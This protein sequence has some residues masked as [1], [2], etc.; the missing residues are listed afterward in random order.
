MLIN[1][2]QK[3]KW[4][5][6]APAE[7]LNN[8]I[9]TM[10]S[11]DW[12][13]EF[14]LTFNACF[15]YSF[16]NLKASLPPLCALFGSLMVSVPIQYYGRRKSLIGLCVPLMFGFMLMGFTYFARHK[17][18]LYI[19]RMLTGFMNGAATPASQIYVTLPDSVWNIFYTHFEI[20][21]NTA[22]KE[23]C[24]EINLIS[25]WN[26]TYSPRKLEWKIW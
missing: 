12:E 6:T 16:C 18:M 26:S 17:S 4:L 11:T 1:L 15:K 23:G 14:S 3:S 25:L 10:F 19:G 7:W 5:T 9:T 21:S 8:T 2:K 13:T 20:I 24:L 22:L